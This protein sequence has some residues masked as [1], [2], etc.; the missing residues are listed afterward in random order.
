MGTKKS[1]QSDGN[2]GIYYYEDKPDE[3]DCPECGGT[4]YDPLDGG[5]CDRC[6]GTGVVD[7]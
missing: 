2:E 4:G 5:Q 7:C 3:K 1:R 6:N